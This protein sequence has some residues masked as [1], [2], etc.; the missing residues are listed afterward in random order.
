MSHPMQEGKG[1]NPP[2]LYFLLYLGP[3]TL[4]DAYTGWGGPPALLT[5]STRMLIL[6]RN[7][8]TK[9]PGNKG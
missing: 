2:F 5:P 6:C 4:G 1:L 7:T 9:T 3:S 8:L